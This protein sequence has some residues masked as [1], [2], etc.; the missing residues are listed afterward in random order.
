MPSLVRAPIGVSVAWPT[1]DGEDNWIT[2]AIL[3][4]ED[5]DEFDVVIVHEGRLRRASRA[6]PAAY[7]VQIDMALFL[8]EPEHA[9]EDELAG[10]PLTDPTRGPDAGAV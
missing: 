5:G 6:L 3:L 9:H 2:P 1:A 4:V 10:L 8:V 7:E